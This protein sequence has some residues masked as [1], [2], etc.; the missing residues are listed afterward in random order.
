[1]SAKGEL[2]IRLRKRLDGELPP[3][4]WPPDFVLR[5]MSEAD[6][7]AVHALL[8]AALDE[9]ERVCRRW[10]A[11]RRAD[12]EF[13]PRLHFLVTDRS[14]RLAAVALCWTSAF[15]KDLA[16]ET[17][18]RRSGVGSALLLHVFHTF[19]ARGERHVDLKTDRMLNADAVRLYGRHGMEEV[20]W[21]G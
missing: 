4:D 9:P 20:D 3:P 21:A 2:Q 8:V 14:G 11:K 1:M 13:D 17:S 19:K 15:I 12:P 7:P 6:A 10:W 16:V 18:A 5:T